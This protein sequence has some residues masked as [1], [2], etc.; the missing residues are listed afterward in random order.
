MPD[1]DF[2]Q[3]SGSRPSGGMREALAFVAMLALAALT[4]VMVLEWVFGID[5]I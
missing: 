1:P 5:L 3:V 4:A 2:V